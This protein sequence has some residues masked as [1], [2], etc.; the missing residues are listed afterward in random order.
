MNDITNILL[1]SITCLPVDICISSGIL[2]EVYL[3]MLKMM[4]VPLIVSS[5]I[6]G[7]SD[8]QCECMWLGC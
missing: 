2:G 3:N 7:N 6:T 8:I 1:S 5:V 4:I